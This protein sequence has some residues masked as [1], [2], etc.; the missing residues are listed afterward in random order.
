MDGSLSL[1][2]GAAPLLLEL[3]AHPER[4]PALDSGQWD[5]LVRVAR[6]TRLLAELGVRMERSGVLDQIPARVCAHVI[7][8][9]VFVRYLQKSAEIEL[10][11]LSRILNQ[12]D[13]PAILLKGAAYIAQRLPIAEGRSMGDVDVMVPRPQ[14]DRVEAAL[15]DEGWVVHP[16]THVAT[17][18]TDAQHE[19]VE[20]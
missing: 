11:R 1:R 3:L 17:G 16:L 6:S 13:V 5:L 7:S 19:S 2:A 8:E 20:L 15:R 18:G 12:L 14:I 9:R 10:R 4:A